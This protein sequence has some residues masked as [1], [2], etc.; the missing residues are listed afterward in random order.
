ME[1]S[2]AVAALSALAQETRLSVFRLLVQAGPEGLPAGDVAQKLDVA[3]ATLSFHLKELSR[4]G[5]I[6]SRQEGRFIY[7]ATHFEH[8]ASLMSF[9][10]QNC[11][12]GMP[13]E[14]LSVMETALQSCCGPAASTRS[15]PA[16]SRS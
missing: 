15:K 7:Y 10:T 4:A 8:M 3:G 11:C 5:L 16:R 6:T 12:K 2:N 9:L 14:C 1:I 13:R